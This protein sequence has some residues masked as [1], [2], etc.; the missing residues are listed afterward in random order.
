MRWKRASDRAIGRNPDNRIAERLG[1]LRNEN[2]RPAIGKS[3][4][5]SARFLARD[6]RALD[7]ADLAM[8]RSWFHRRHR[9]D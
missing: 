4:R 5:F 3:A 6:N 9:P 7:G 2:D 1:A 8:H